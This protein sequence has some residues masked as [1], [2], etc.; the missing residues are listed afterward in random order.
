[1]QVEM[2][3]NVLQFLRLGHVGT[4]RHYRRCV[5]LEMQDQWLQA[6]S[7]HLKRIDRLVCTFR[8]ID[9]DFERCSAKRVP[10]GGRYKQIS[11]TDVCAER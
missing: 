11:K 6:S 3:W 5:P 8:F 7:L 1:M 10:P 4:V 9:P 2:C